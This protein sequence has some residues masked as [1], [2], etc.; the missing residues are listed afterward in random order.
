MAT[1][2]ALIAHDEKKEELLDLVR[3]HRD[4]FELCDLIATGTTGQQ[5][6]RWAGLIVQRVASGALRGDLQIG[7]KVVEGSIDA[8]I[9]LRDPLTAHPHE[10]DI[11]ALL[12]TC[13][14]HE[15]PV[16]TN[17][18]SAEILIGHLRRRAQAAALHP[19]SV[20]A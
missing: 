8:V 5:I 15:V 1:T 9:F 6:Q 12:K 11:Q 10:P 16:A 7:A 4:V 14:V 13:D 3:V 19:A 20:G 2:M 17:R 18:R